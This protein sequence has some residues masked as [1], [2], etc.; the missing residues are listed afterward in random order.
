MSSGL[1]YL[2]IKTKLVFNIGVMEFAGIALWCGENVL[3]CKRSHDMEKFPNTWSV[4]AGYVEEGETPLVCSIRELWEE[5][6]IPVLEKYTKLAGFIDK[7]PGMFYLY[8]TD[9]P[10]FYTP[11][12]DCEHSDFGY[13]SLDNLPTPM[14]PDMII[15]LKKIIK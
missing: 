11:L 4:P 14:D 6:H 7:K 13:F 8:Y 5:T 1:Y 2:K 3:L 9:I 10:E 15:L 12:L